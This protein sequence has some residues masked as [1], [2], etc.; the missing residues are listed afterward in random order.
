LLGEKKLKRTGISRISPVLFNS[1][2][3]QYL[4]P[5]ATFIKTKI[6]NQLVHAILDS[7]AVTS[8][9]S[10]KLTKKLNINRICKEEIN[11]NFIAANGEKLKTLGYCLI[12][13]NIGQIK[14]R[15][16]CIIIDKLAIS[17]FSLVKIITK[18]FLLSIK[19]FDKSKIY[20]SP[21]PILNPYVV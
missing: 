14:I 8:L 9:I 20:F 6:N 7:G 4:K 13:I 18:Q 2:N 11:T 3:P 5:S 17:I 1:C 21:P 19:Y 10:L 12:E 16:K 15:Q